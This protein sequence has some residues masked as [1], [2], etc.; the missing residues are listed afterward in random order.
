MAER[1]L[2]P[3]K[4]VSVGKQKQLVKGSGFALNTANQNLAVK[5]LVRRSEDFNDDTFSRG[6]EWYASAQKDAHH[7]GEGNVDIGASVLST[8]S[9]KTNYQINR[10]MALH[11]MALTPEHIDALKQH[12]TLART[13]AGTGGDKNPA[14]APLIEHAAKLRAATVG[15]TPLSYTP[16]ATILR[17]HKILHGELHPLGVFDVIGVKG[18]RKSGPKKQFDFAGQIRSGGKFDDFAPIDTHAYDAAM[19]N[20]DIPYGTANEHMKSGPVYDFIHDAYKKA[21]T[22]SISAGHVPKGTTIG[23]YQ[24]IHWVHQQNLKAANRPSVLSGMV[25]QQESALKYAASLPHLDP[26]KHGLDPIESSESIVSRISY[27]DQGS[28]EGRR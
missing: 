11:V 16:S 3:P 12:V 23:Q 8:L 2:K 18:Q 25:S 4:I 22:K 27:F 20:I 19:D 6:M 24:A 7:V 28:G 5:N 10:Q 17:A 26:A 13:I 14:N 15:G 21:L 1:R 9:G